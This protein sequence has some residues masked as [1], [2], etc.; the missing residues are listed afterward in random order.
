MR[1]RWWL[2]GVVVGAVAF[3]L[4]VSVTSIVSFAYR[5]PSLH[6]AVET[7]AAL[8]ATLA[9][10]LI[11][12]RF[13][14]SL[15]RRDL[16]LAS[17]LVLFAGSNLLFSMV[18]AIAGAGDD[19]FSTWAPAFSSIASA[20]FLAAAAFTPPRAV[21]RP[22]EAMRRALVLCG[23]VLGVIALATLLAGD[24]LPLAIDPGLSPE[25]GT[26]PRIIGDPVVLGL[27]I[28]IMALFAAAAAGFARSA[29]LARDPL[30]LWF[31]IGA[32]L[33]AFA[34]VN[35]FLF[36][37]RYS[38]FFYTGDVLRL[39]FFI[40]LFIGGAYEIRVA[41][42]EL[43]R[44]AVLHERRRLAREIHDGMAQDLAF[45]VQQAD[46][47]SARNGTMADIATAARR[48]LDESR[49][50]IAA[51]VRPTDEP[52]EQAL[53][54]IAG[55]AAGRWGETEVES[56]APAGVEL[57][58]PAREALLRIVG[59]AVTNAARHGRARRV[60]VELSEGPELQVRIA[61]DGV[62]FDPATLEV[63]AGRHGIVGMRERAEQIGGHLR[64][65]SKPGEGTEITVVLP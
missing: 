34:R 64:V 16:L 27:Q 38:E 53:E 17:A 49:S 29:E 7:A 55:E 19:P 32:T 2:A 18:P 5:S 25:A 13:R 40:S 59:E 56:R 47:L 42:R 21:R 43:E 12:G 63:D 22:V 28:V 46:A 15:D 4:I 48:A 58:A 51:L 14:R 11:Y 50:A 61:D 44:A 30:M 39:G 65:Q 41:Q 26:R 57:A 60:R 23:V 10:Q 33:G 62:G 37:S 9:A 36:P 6:V 45:I 31:A 54:R 1:P 8:I 24:A 20:G 3:T 35:Y 52:L